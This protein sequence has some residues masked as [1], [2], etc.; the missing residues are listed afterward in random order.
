MLFT[1]IDKCMRGGDPEIK[2]ERYYYTD[3]KLF[4]QSLDIY[5]PIPSASSGNT[6]TK[7]NMVPS[8]S[9][10]DNYESP[11]LDV[12]HQPI[13]VA[14]VVGS[15]WLGH[16]SIIY[17]Q[18]S[19]WNSS[20]P[21]N[22]ASLGHVCVCIRHRGSFPKLFSDLTFLFVAIMVGIFALFVAAV[23]GKE[24]VE[25]MVAGGFMGV[26]TLVFALSLVAI[27]LA[28]HGSASFEDMQ[29]DVMD[30]LVWLDVNKERLQLASC[31]DAITSTTNS[32]LKTSKPFF[33]FGGYSS[34]G[35]TAATVSQQPQMWKDRNLPLPHIY[36][37]AMLYISPVLSTKPYND[38]EKYKSASPS[39]D[40]LPSLRRTSTLSTPVPPQ[41]IS[42]VSLSSMD[43]FSEAQEAKKIKNLP[44]SLT[45]SSP[46][47]QPPPP[48]W[49]TNRLVKTVFGDNAAQA[50]PSPIHEYQ[51]S[52]S[53]P[54]IF[55]GCEHE[56]FGL[57]WLDVFFCSNAF[58]DLLQ[59]K[60]IDSRY[61]SVKSDHWN[62]LN[63][64]ELS[65]ALEQELG[66]MIHKSIGKKN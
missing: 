26:I 31:R 20:G 53:V 40:A 30:A 18:T 1:A 50:I 41:K 66:L 15:A 51:R 61:A 62:I 29:N 25:E 10:A 46:W 3:N 65:K 12:K 9:S 38:L 33:V 27:E 36:C 63:S 19:W 7:I 17:S 35:H 11:V 37:D 32:G 45:S 8:P 48:D 23:G 52:P 2:C 60:G 34:G 4:E 47:P 16:R 56:M 49:L 42:S 13:V 28:G 54:H 39:S 5:R 44:L 43:E 6:S 57:N 58:N 64:V 22:V 55:L 59:G 14:L 21:K 24:I